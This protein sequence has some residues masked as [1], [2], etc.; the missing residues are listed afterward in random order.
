MTM[1][2]ILYALIDPRT[3][4]VRYVGASTR[5]MARP[6]EHGTAYGRR[7]RT[8]RHAWLKQLWLKGLVP[9]ILVLGGYADPTA[10]Y[11][12]E[13]R[14]IAEFRAAG[15]DLVNMTDGGE[16]TKGRR[17][18]PEH[19]RKLDRSHGKCSA[20]VRAAVG[21]AHRGTRLSLEQ[22]QK[23]SVTM[24][25]RRISDEHRRN[26]AMAR[27]RYWARVKESR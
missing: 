22:K 9:S 10:M 25:G 16:G 11:A 17:L 27:C 14:T 4:D 26:I 19:R 8:H 2:C 15:F 6:K 3:G 5:G 23:I 1:N 7:G 12:A 20:E 13:V 21:N 24:T 18:T